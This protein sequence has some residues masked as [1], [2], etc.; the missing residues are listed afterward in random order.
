MYTLE[1]PQII[2]YH[3][4][5]EL[6]SFLSTYN[7]IWERL[8]PNHKEDDIHVISDELKIPMKCPVTLSEINIPAKGFLC[9]HV[10][11]RI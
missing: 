8:F 6:E 9:A 5:Y 3:K 4:I 10:E 11:V 2:Q 7:M 1:I